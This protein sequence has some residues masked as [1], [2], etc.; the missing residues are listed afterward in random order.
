MVTMTE[1]YSKNHAVSYTLHVIKHVVNTINCNDYNDVS[2]AGQCE[3]LQMCWALILSF[4][5]S[6]YFFLS[7]LLQLQEN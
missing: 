1:M 5:V 6:V 4:S 7:Y 3:D 2:V